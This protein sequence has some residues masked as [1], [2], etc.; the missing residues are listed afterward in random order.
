MFNPEVR[1]GQEQ[2]LKK[3]ETSFS[4]AWI[5]DADPLLIG[6]KNFANIENLRYTNAGLE[7]VSGYTALTTIALARPA[8]RSAI[9]FVKVITSTPTSHILVQG[10]GG[11]TSAV[12][13]HLSVVPAAAEWTATAL[14]T[15]ASGAG[16]G[17]FALGPDGTLVYC[18]GKD[19]TIWG[20]A[21]HRVAAVINFDV[22]SG[23]FRFDMTSTVTNRIAPSFTYHTLTYDSNNDISLLVGSTRPLQGINVTMS[24][25]NLGAST[26]EVSYWNGSAWVAVSG[27]SD[28]TAVG[29]VTL[30]QSGTMSFTSTASTARVKWED[31]RLL[32]FYKLLIGATGTPV[33]AIVLAQ[34]TVDAPWQNVVDVWDG[35]ERLPILCVVATIHEWTLDILEASSGAAP[36][37]AVLDGLT[38]GDTI[39]VGFEERLTALHLTM[40]PA[41]TS[42]TAAT[43]TVKYWN[44]QAWGTV[45]TITDGT[46]TGG[47]ALGQSG[48][49][50]WDAPAASG[51]FQ[52]TINGRTGYFYQLTLSAN[53]PGNLFDETPNYKIIIDTITGIPAQRWN[54][55]DPVPAYTFPFSFA[56][57]VM[58]AG[59]VGTNAL[60]RIDYCAP[61]RPDVWAGE[62]ASDR[63][64]EIYVGDDQGLTG[65]IEL[66]N[67]YLNQLAQICVVLKASQTWLLQG[68]NADDFTL[69]RIS[70]TVG[71]PAP[72]S[73][74][75]AEIPSQ[76]EG[77]TLRNVV[78]W[79]SAKGPVLFD[80]T[81][82]LPMRFPMQDGAISSVECYFDPNDSRY[83]NTA[84]W[85]AV[86]GWYD[87][88]KS[89]YNLLLPSGSG[90]TTCNVWLF[91]DLR[92]RKWGRKVPSTYPQVGIPVQDI[93]GTPYTYGTLD[94]G[95]L[96]RLESG[97]TWAGSSIAHVLQTA[98]VPLSGSSGSVFDETLARF[99]RVAAISDSGTGVVTISHSPNG[100][101]T[102]TA[103]TTMTLNGSGRF[104]VVTKPLN[105]RAF[106]H[107]WQ[108][109]CTTSDA[110][111]APRLLGMGIEWLL[112]RAIER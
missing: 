17:R 76:S 35:V 88:Q 60:N 48:T 45:G 29:G 55:Q 68:S 62:Q 79:C 32:Y 28:G 72:L 24:N 40:C 19:T 94:T 36:I 1:V 71:C 44:G 81:I 18:N 12:Y 27:F 31:E 70:E 105:R 73:L 98:D 101:A 59:L 87:A 51:E 109:S 25:A 8:I 56:G 80:G 4:G 96:L 65:A 107:Q 49:V 16:L 53:L 61:R 52:K 74:C 9:Q 20:S 3:W 5:P 15:D 104:Q 78:I 77:Q 38:A 99:L 103:Q 89:E 100:T 83:V 90:Q 85:T 37:G 108:L 30:A 23:A 33:G 10:T 111:R 7:G 69:Y 47:H 91:C 106:S 41:R 110:A 2:D 75:L 21:T 22:V 39:V 97:N 64:K 43:M 102:F 86:Q 14:W 13:Q 93:R 92:R 26:T 84:S 82:I 34:V 112:E 63:G 54:A 95:H 67:R 46:S 50:S 6:E 42:L 66:T 58:L 57:R 11:G